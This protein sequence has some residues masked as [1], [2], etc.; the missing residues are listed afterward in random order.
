MRYKNYCE[1]SLKKFKHI[2]KEEVARGLDDDRSACRYNTEEKE[3]MSN[4]FEHIIDNYKTD[5]KYDYDT[6]VI[7]TQ[8]ETLGRIAE[9][10]DDIG[11]QI[12][13]MKSEYWDTVGDFVK[14]GVKDALRGPEGKEM[15][16]AAVKEVLEGPQ[17]K[18]IILGVM[19]DLFKGASLSLDI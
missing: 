9:I 11:K 18:E 14:V 12:S 6:A 7:D 3:E 17:G 10:E 8:D 13:D 5:M 19:K 16:L 2:I 15:I 4:H 1:R